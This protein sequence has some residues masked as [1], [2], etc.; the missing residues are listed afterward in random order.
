M[1]EQSTIHIGAKE[2]AIP[3]AQ[4]PV[5]QQVKKAKSKNIIEQ[6][7]IYLAKLSKVKTSDKVTFFRLLATMINAGIS[8]VKALNILADQTE[9]P[10]MKTIDLELANSIE[11]GKSFSEALK[12]FPKVFSDAQVGMVEAGEASGRL[13][14]TLL[15]IAGETEK[16]AA[17]MSKIKGAMI[18]PIVVIF[19]MLGAGF[20]VMTFVMPKIKEM[21]ESLGGE[22]P[23]M[24]MALINASD[25]MVGSTIGIPNALWVVIALIAF[26]TVFTIWKRTDS[27][28]YLWAQAVFY[29][30]VFGKLSKKVAIARFCRGLST[31]I[32]SGISI[33]KALNIT[34][35]SVGNAVYEKRILQIADDVRQGITMAENMKDDEEHF[36]SMVVGMIGVAE[37]TAQI[38]QISSKLADFYEEEVNDMVKGLSSLLEPIIIVVLGG[39]VAF[40]VIAVMMPI[41][42]VSDL[43]SSAT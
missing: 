12:D 30:P 17:L 22:L 27:G 16:S 23:P 24:T 37:Q 42:S 13:N 9:N 18:Y 15:E 10:A 3:Q 11:S 6:L 35:A 34:A 14:Q 26:V 20:A 5:K 29:I 21:F 43:A 36:P 41:L 28:K 7:N 2:T 32:S 33:L 31:M 1:S 8:I 39:A 40:L 38:D 19:I 25:F 4:Q